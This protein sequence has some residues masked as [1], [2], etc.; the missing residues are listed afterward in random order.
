LRGVGLGFIFGGLQALVITDGSQ[1]SFLVF[2]TFTYNNL[3]YAKFNV[4]YNI[5][6]Q[7]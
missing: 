3:V 1:L 5:E 2:G 6:K 7:Q 4:L